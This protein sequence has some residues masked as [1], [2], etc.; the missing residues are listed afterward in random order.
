ME[1]AEAREPPRGT[2]RKEQVVHTIAIEIAHAE[3]AKGIDVVHIARANGHI[4]RRLQSDRLPQITPQRK[5]ILVDEGAVWKTRLASDV[6][7]VAFFVLPSVPHERELNACVA[8]VPNV[9]R[10][11]TKNGPAFRK[12][13]PVW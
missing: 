12:V 2:G 9:V 13:R 3:M 4:L 5:D 11:R 10:Q 7:V 6:N 8:A 1:L